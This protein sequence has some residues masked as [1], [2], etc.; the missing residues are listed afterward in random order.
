MS[1]P[2]QHDYFAEFFAHYPDFHYMPTA[3]ITDEFYRLCDQKG[4]DREDPERADAKE[5]FND[6]LVQTFNTIYGTDEKDIVSWQSLC[7]ILRIV[8]IP[9]DLEA[10]V[11]VVRNTHVNLVDLVDHRGQ[12]VHIFST[13]QD[14]QKYT[15][16]G[17]YFP[18]ENAYA[19]GLLKYLLREINGEYHG[20]K[21][22]QR[23]KGRGMRRKG[24]RGGV[25]V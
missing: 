9:Q 12:S 2:A 21:T 17:K 5:L 24:R 3:S 11:E 15:R 1:S 4:W 10:C 20:S 13:L 7:A 19:G 8:P 23:R 18:K 25:A 22:G 16:A 6:A 14:L